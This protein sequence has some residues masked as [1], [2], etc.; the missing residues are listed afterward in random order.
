MR[1]HRNAIELNTI[2]SIKKT[3]N[4]NLYY[5]DIPEEK[6]FFFNVKFDHENEP[7]LGCGKCDSE[8]KNKKN[9][10]KCSRLT[11]LNLMMT[12]IKLMRNIENE[13][14]IVSLNYMFLVTIYIIVTL[15]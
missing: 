11:H 8:H 6:F 10:I 13:G 9:G 7:I 4:D 5:D 2:N 1:R 12:S 15:L 14:N 3:V